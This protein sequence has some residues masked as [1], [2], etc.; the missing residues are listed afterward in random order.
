[1][2]ALCELLCSAAAMPSAPPC[3]GYVVAGA[4]DAASNGCYTV[5]HGSGTYMKDAA[6]SLYA[7]GGVWRL[8]HKNGTQTAVS[9]VATVKGGPPRAPAQ[10]ACGSESAPGYP[11]GFDGDACPPPTLSS[12]QPPTPPRPLFPTPVTHSD[13]DVECAVKTSAW[14]FA[15][16]IQPWRGAHLAVFD[17]LELRTRCNASRPAAQRRR[18]GLS[19]R[20]ACSGAAF[21]ADALHGSDSGS[22]SASAPFASVRRG[23]QACRA[24]S[25]TGASACFIYVSDSAPFVLTEPLALTSADSGLTIAAKPAATSAP[26]ITS[27]STA[28]INSPWV[29][30]SANVWKAKLSEGYAG[31]AVYLN[32]TR[33]IAARW[34]NVPDS[35]TALVPVGYVGALSWLPP[36]PRAPAI[37]VAQPNATRRWDKTFP[38]WFWGRENESVALPASER[39]PTFDPPEGYWMHP[40]PKGGA[41]WEVPSG[42]VYDAPSFSPRAKTW[43]NATT[44]RARAFHSQYW[45][46]CMGLSD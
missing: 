6:H 44:G 13:V 18:R 1:M 12:S 14:R 46:N 30:V 16:H 11:H 15:Q 8:A 10:W 27:A 7:F 31:G 23:V 35:A 21:H 34:P 19:E 45:G 25:T 33:A 24:A 39:P 28:A 36:R 40:H 4:G 2:L 41:M 32:G 26:V 37:V 20:S 5:H 29:R 42:L 9:Y 43:R 22:G 3:D 38:T 17:A